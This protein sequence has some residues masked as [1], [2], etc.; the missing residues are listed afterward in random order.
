MRPFFFIYCI[1][2][3][4]LLQAKEPQ[5]EEVLTKIDQLYRS[6]SSIA[7]LEM[8]ISSPSWT[9]SLKLKA[10]SKGID[11]TFIRVLSPKKEK[12]I[13]TLRKGKEMWNYFPKIDRLFKVPPSMMMGSWMGSDF[14]NDDLV[15]E[16]SLLHD[17]EAKF[18]PTKE[19]LLLSLVPKAATVSLWGEIQILVEKES[20]LPLLQSYFDEHGEKIRELH[21]F[22]VQEF[23]GRLVPARLEMR[24]LQK[25]G[26]KTSIIY[27]KL[28]FNQKIDDAIFSLRE[29]KKRN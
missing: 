3:V 27:H 14:S 11:Q 19:H 15:K 18:L 29:L 8:R 22:D 21:F 28:H 16:S 5:I 24:P 17:Y 2:F 25:E 10:Y 20:Y 9:R 23:S 13:T 7:E 12:G 1:F 26:H 6:E 4:F